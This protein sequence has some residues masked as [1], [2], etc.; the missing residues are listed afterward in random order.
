MVP[1]HAKPS[2]APAPLA[3]AALA[4]LLLLLTTDATAQ[5]RE[6]LWTVTCGGAGA[7]VGGPSK[8]LG[9]RPALGTRP[10]AV[11][12]H[13]AGSLPAAGEHRLGG[14]GS[15]RREFAGKPHPA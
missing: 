6:R 3:T 15:G 12:R 14:A 1:S 8:V 13:H 4:A 10:G 9:N 5:T 7:W 2:A 11:V